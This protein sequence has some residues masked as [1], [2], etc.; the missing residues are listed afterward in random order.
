MNDKH[1]QRPLPACNIETQNRF[2]P[3]RSEVQ[4]EVRNEDNHTANNEDRRQ[5]QQQQQQQQSHVDSSEA[6]RAFDTIPTSHNRYQA[7]HVPSPS[8]QVSSEGPLHQSGAHA[9]TSRISVKNSIS[10]EVGKTR[11]IVLIGDSVIKHIDPKK[12]SQ[13]HVH[14]FSYPGKTTGEIAEAV[15][16]IAVASDPSHIII[17]TGTNNL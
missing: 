10:S 3:L 13:R 5:Q 9:N 15:D 17:H 16:N 8:S 4:V 14:K 12:L 1:I 7:L 11:H 6:N 2:Q